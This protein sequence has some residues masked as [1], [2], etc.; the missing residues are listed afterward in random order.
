[1]DNITILNNLQRKSKE[2]SDANLLGIRLAKTHIR[3]SFLA[4]LA[5]S[6]DGAHGLA[7]LAEVVEVLVGDNF[8]LDEAPLKVAVDGAGGLRSKAVPRDRPASDFL[9]TR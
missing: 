6:L 1:M 5:S 8:S 7:A 9:F 3:L 2:I 4:V